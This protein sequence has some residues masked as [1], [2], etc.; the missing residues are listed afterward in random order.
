MRGK[1]VILL[2]RLLADPE[3]AFTPSG[4]GVASFQLVTSPVPPAAGEVSDQRC[5]AW[6]QGGRRL[7]DLVLE[8]LQAGGLVYLEGYLQEAPREA[9]QDRQAGSPNL[10][11][12]WDLQLLEPRR[13][14]SRA[15]SRRRGSRP[16]MEDG[17]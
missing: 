11:L 13:K 2:G 6:N 12:V 9:R 7:A 16:G 15:V 14:A 5:L 8:H 1:P 17:E 3:L 4:E 10:L